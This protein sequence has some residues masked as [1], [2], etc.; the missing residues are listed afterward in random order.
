MNDR[1]HL[2]RRTFLASLGAGAASLA[3]MPCLVHAQQAAIRNPNVIIIFSDDQGYADV[4]VYGAKGFQTPNLDKLAAEGSRFTDFHVPCASCAPSRAALLTGSYP[5]RVGF[6]GNNA[7][8]AGLNPDEYTLADL[9]NDAGYRSFAIGKWHLGND[10]ATLPLAH[11]F[12]SWLGLIQNPHKV[13]KKGGRGI[14]SLEYWKQFETKIDL[15]QAFEKAKAE[16][17]DTWYP[18]MRDH[19]LVEFPCDLDDLEKKH[20]EEAVRI[21]DTVKDKPFFI[22][23][24]LNRPHLPW[25]VSDQFKGTSELGMYGDMMHELDWQVGQIREALE[26]NGVADN[27]IIIFTSDNGP[28]PAQGRGGSTGPFRG[29]K[30]KWWEGGHRVP[31]II[32]YPGKVPAGEVSEEY[33]TTM[34]F[35]PTFADIVGVTLP[36]DR[37]IDGKNALPLWFGEEGAKS[38]YD[39]AHNFFYD[40]GPGYVRDGKWKLM[41]GY[42]KEELKGWQVGRV[43]EEHSL[44]NLEEDPG[45][46]TNLAAEH[47]ERVSEYV[48]KT[49]AAYEQMVKH[50]RPTYA[51]A[52]R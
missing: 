12:E 45:E 27:T 33:L 39:I 29:S 15:D 22:Y 31:F 25:R 14:K 36:E 35:L 13:R 8:D 28:I 52:N 4:G 46:T 24:A 9:F 1:H 3:A 11:G 10:K 48:E 5:Q 6:G 51:E 37:I 30:R 34:D 7:V 42:D 43:E 21:V 2:S 50:A 20:A 32:W 44:Y 38:P 18:L 17:V 40:A 41:Y 49:E 16:E 47:P 26:R 19:S 23:L